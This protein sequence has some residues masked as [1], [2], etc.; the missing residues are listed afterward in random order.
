MK[1]SLFAPVARRFPL[2][3]AV[4]VPSGIG[5]VLEG[6][7]VSKFDGLT[8]KTIPAGEV[9]YENPNSVMRSRNGSSTEVVKNVVFLLFF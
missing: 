7:F 8:A 2:V 9:F 4:A 1:T 3:V 6:T 5:Y